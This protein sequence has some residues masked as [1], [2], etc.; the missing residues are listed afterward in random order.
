MSFE[1][2]LDVEARK[3]IQPQL[4]ALNGPHHAGRV[5]Y[6]ATTSLD[7]GRWPTV[8]GSKPAMASFGHSMF[9]C[10]RS[11]DAYCWCINDSRVAAESAGVSLH[12]TALLPILAELSILGDS[13]G[14]NVLNVM[15]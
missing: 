15:A 5:L 7:H 9:S 10:F 11:T 1:Y 8:G 14:R 6:S 3:N 12:F 13:G 4:Y 2:T